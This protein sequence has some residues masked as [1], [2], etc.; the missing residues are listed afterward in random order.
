MIKLEILEKLAPKRS[1]FV[2]KS[3]LKLEN[4]IFLELVTYSDSKFLNS[5]KLE[6]DEIKI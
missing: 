6:F 4:F 2:S 5:M 1:K 3:E